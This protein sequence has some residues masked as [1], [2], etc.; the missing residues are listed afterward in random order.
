MLNWKKVKNIF[1]FMILSG[2]LIS[3]ICSCSSGEKSAAST[4]SGEENIGASVPVDAPQPKPSIAP[5]KLTVGDV[6][7]DP[8]VYDFWYY[9]SMEQYGA[10]MPAN[11]QGLPDVTALTG[12][13]ET[14]TWADVLTA[15]TI[16]TIQYTAIM[17]KEAEKRNISL[18]EED[19]AGITNFFEG[20]KTD[21][22]YYN[23]KE[24]DIL[25]AYF[26]EHASKEKIVAVLEGFFLAQKGDLA[27][28][29]EFEFTEDEIKEYYEENKEMIGSWEV[30]TVRHIL[31]G[32]EEGMTEE[33]DAAAKKSADEVLAKIN[34]GED[35]AVLGEQLL[36]EGNIVESA[37]Y[38]VQMGQMVPEFEEWCFAKDR[39]KG[40]TGIV[41]TQ[42]GYHVMFLSEFKDQSENVLNV[43]KEEAF[44]EFLDE[45][46]ASPEFKLVTST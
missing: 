16:E 36:T 21:A 1:V 24:E 28:F 15:Q 29:D 3:G 20:A 35:M 34:G 26:G 18:D 30:P 23:I 25:L 22:E 46:L 8:V 4:V 41:K 11:D 5:S 17:I 45:K 10:Y 32:F 14:E 31:Y 13:D 9:N 39:K 37:E 42:Y 2:I 43:L 38:E 12:Q 6:D 33:E 40:D 27:V 44:V 19:Q 7:I